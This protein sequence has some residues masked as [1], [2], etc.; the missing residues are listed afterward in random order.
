MGPVPHGHRR[1]GG[2]PRRASSLGPAAAELGLVQFEF[3]E[4]WTRKDN[5]DT[6][7]PHLKRAM[8]SD[9]VALESK[10]RVLL[11]CLLAQKM[12]PTAT[13][14]RLARAHDDGPRC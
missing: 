11:G 14:Q 10:L 13:L 2:V 9:D 12:P 6:A 3:A 4:L 5:L 1:L 8:S 7:L